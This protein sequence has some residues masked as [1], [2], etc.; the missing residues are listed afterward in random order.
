MYSLLHHNTFGIDAQCAEFVEYDS[1]EKLQTLLP[2]LQGKRWLQIGGGSNLL[3]VKD[4]DGVVLHSRIVGCDEVHRDTHNV[5]LR[6]GAGVVWDE[7]VAYCVEHGFYGLENLSLIPGEVGASAVQNIG[8]YGVEACQYIEKV[9]A[10]DVATG[11][12]RTFDT[13]SCQYAYRSSISTV[14]QVF[15]RFRLRSHTQGV[16]TA[17]HESC[18]THSTGFAEYDNSNK[19]VEIARPQGIG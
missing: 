7:F 13:Q 19:A 9:E 1:V 2:S 16:R 10:I 12:L 4:F 14:T 6:V 11:A 18:N 3:F 8:A 17:W 5:W 15:S